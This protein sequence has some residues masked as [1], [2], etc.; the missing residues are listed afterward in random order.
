ML[1]PL[2]EEYVEASG[3]AETQENWYGFG[4]ILEF[5]A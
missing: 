4:S 3:F 2:G 5:L 1:R